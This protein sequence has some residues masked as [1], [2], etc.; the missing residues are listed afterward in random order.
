M[1]IV[2]WVR[3]LEQPCARRYLACV[4]KLLYEY[5]G[6]SETLIYVLLCL[7]HMLYLCLILH[8]SVY[9]LSLCFTFF[10]AFHMLRLGFVFISLLNA[11][12]F[13]HMSMHYAIGV[14]S[15]QGKWG[16]S[17]IHLSMH[18]W[19][20]FCLTMDL[21]RLVRWVAL[22]YMLAWIFHVCVSALFWL[23]P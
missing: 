3:V 8:V 2:F 13:I 12:T 21:N 17:C 5:A 19:I 10:F 22:S 9:S 6:R 23:L 20:W 4:C 7:F 1:F 18:I 15:L 14:E 11:M 16:K